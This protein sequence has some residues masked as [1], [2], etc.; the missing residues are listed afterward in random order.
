VFEVNVKGIWLCCQAIA[1]IMT[2]QGRGKII[3]IS[4]AIINSPGGHLVLHYS[5]TKA[6]VKTMTQLLARAL[7]PSGININAIAPGYTHTDASMRLGDAEASFEHAVA[8]QCIKRREEPED[9]VGTAVFLAS[10]DSDFIT[11]QYV[12]VDGGNWLR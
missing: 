7:G 8:G 6:A 3:N 10:K 9:L 4:S 11:G 1:P 2:K 5:C 12:I